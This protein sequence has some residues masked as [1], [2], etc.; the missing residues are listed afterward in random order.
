MAAG[1]PGQLD[2]AVVL[3]EGGH[4]EGGEDRRQHGVG[5]IGQHAPLD[6]CH[7]D[8]P[9][10]GLAGDVR[11]GGHVAYGFQRRHHEDDGERHEQ[12]PVKA[13]AVVEREWHHDQ[14]TF[15]GRG[16]D[17]A[18]QQGDGVARQH[19][20][21]DGGEAQP[22]IAAALQQH[23]EAEYQQGEKE[24][25][26]AGEAAIRERGVAAPHAD[27]AHLD[28]GQADEQHHYAGHQG[29]D[30]ALDQMQEAAH[31]HYGEGGRQHGAKQGAQQILGGHGGLFEGEAGGD[32]GAEEV[33]AGALH[34]EQ[35]RAEGTEAA[36]LD[37]GGDAGHHQGHGDD[38]AG[39]GGREAEGIG[40]DEGRG[41]DGDK[42]GEHVLQGGEQGLGQGRNLVDAVDQFTVGS[43]GGMG[44]GS[45]AHGGSLFHKYL[46]VC[47]EG[48]KIGRYFSG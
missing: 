13:D 48:E 37:E 11:G 36:G 30:D 47:G 16:A 24:V 38:V 45:R 40:D 20:D 4:G 29:G 17:L 3:G 6:P 39:V 28:Q 8:G 2:D 12:L 18:Q 35:T 25:G 9:V 22:G 15:E 34:R 23:D 1:D 46:E 5:A 10:Q 42:H 32:D 41:D 44:L 31:H 33:E 19:G 7:V 27:E 43:P 26:V 14:G 21:H